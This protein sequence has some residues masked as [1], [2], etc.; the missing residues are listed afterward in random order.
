ME[1]ESPYPPGLSRV[2]PGQWPNCLALVSGPVLG[3]AN[4]PRRLGL[5][6]DG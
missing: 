4:N 2:H 3:Q 5:T 6:N 1:V